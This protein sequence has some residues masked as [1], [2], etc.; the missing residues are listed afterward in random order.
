LAAEN[1]IAISTDSAL[2]S[3]NSVY[4]DALDGFSLTVPAGWQLGTGDALGGAASSDPKARFSNAAGLQRVVAFIPPSTSDVNLAITVRT[5]SADFTS[6][7][8]FGTAQQWAESLISA[9]DRSYMLKKTAPQNG[10]GA[11][12]SGGEAVPIAKLVDVKD[13]NGQYIV[14]YTVSREGSPTRVVISAVA[15]G[16]SPRS[17]VRRFYTINGSCTT[18][19]EGKFGEILQTAVASFTAPSSV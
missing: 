17:G 16:V 8:S 15:L 13:K 18:E 9:M 12:S 3:S 2:S 5:P 7:G 19:T 4:T 14:R 11:V 6:L 1:N 10:R